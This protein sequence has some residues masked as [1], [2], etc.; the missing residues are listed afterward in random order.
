M[1]KQ[2]KERFLS[3]YYDALLKNCIY[4][5]NIKSA[6]KERN[7]VD[8]FW[9][10][11]FLESD[12]SFNKEYEIYGINEKN[13]C[14]YMINEVLFDAIEKQDLE[15]VNRC[16]QMICEL[17]CTGMEN[18]DVFLVSQYIYNSANMKRAAKRVNQNRFDPYSYKKYFYYSARVCEYFLEEE[19]ISFDETLLL[20]EFAVAAIIDISKKIPEIY[21][22]IEIYN[23][24]VDIIEK[25]KQKLKGSKSTRKK[26]PDF[27]SQN[28]TA[29]KYLKKTFK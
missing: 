28:D 3:Y 27:T 10:F 11:E 29:Q 24:A 20:N 17:N 13:N 7:I 8:E 5:D 15:K 18:E 6:L 4:S 9:F 14:Y 21:E 1:E 25:N 12:I 19:K 26:F 16:N 23:K 22:N 2:T